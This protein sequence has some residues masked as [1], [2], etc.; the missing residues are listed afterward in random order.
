MS[1]FLDLTKT[2]K[3]CKDK[4]YKSEYTILKYL[5]LVNNEEEYK[6]IKE[7][8]KQKVGSISKLG[9]KRSLKQRRNLSKTEKDEI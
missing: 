6:I 1:Q 4:F 5:Q 8:R 9:K 3:Q 2:P 7:N